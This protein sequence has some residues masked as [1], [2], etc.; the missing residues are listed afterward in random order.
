MFLFVNPFVVKRCTQPLTENSWVVHN[1]IPFASC[2]RNK[3]CP[4]ML[5]TPRNHTG[6]KWSSRLNPFAVVSLFID[7][8]NLLLLTRGKSRS[9]N[10][11]GEWWK[12][13]RHE[14]CKEGQTT[15]VVFI[16]SYNQNNSMLSLFLKVLVLSRVCFLLQ[17]LTWRNLPATQQITLG[18]AQVWLQTLIRLKHQMKMTH[19]VKWMM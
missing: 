14:T 8:F 11:F 1:D 15:P 10:F 2:R 18:I 13:L 4:L 3:L 17:K 9:E 16:L 5:I 19:L 6:S 12:R 7:K